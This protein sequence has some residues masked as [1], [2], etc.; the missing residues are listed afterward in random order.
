MWIKPGAPDGKKFYQ[1][2]TGSVAPRPIALASTLDLDGHPNLSP[3]SFFNCFGSNP[4]MLIFSPLRRV[5]DAKT[6][7]TLDNVRHIPEVVIN[8]VSYAMVEQTS[9]ASCE[10]PRGVNEFE[11]SGFTPLPARSI[12]PFRVAESPVHF[13]CRVTQ[14]LETGQQGGAGNLILCEILGMHI[15]QEILD[16]DGYVDPDKIDLVARMGHHY[17]CRASGPSVMTVPKPSTE[18][19]IGMD[20]LPEAIR[21]SPVLSG[22]DLGRLAS[23]TEMPV[24][25]DAFEDTRLT[26]IHQSLATDPAARDKALHLYARELVQAGR[27]QEAWQVLLSAPTSGNRDA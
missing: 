27:V 15:R 7:H 4:P 22:N 19:C 16:A 5:R 26:R 13:E 12:R 1:L 17:Y 8:V 11:K 20:Q 21:H 18:L 23:V 24:A 2:L 25:D 14:V 10:Y 6:K 3:F 9:L